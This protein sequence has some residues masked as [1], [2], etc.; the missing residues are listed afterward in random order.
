MARKLFKNASK[1]SSFAV[2]IS[3]LVSGSDCS[4]LYRQLGQYRE[5]LSMKQSTSCSHFG[6]YA[7]GLLMIYRIFQFVADKGKI[8]VYGPDGF[9]EKIGEKIDLVDGMAG[10]AGAETSNNE[11]PTP[12]IECERQW[13]E[14]LP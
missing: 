10:H 5:P 6:Q 2:R 13:L 1:K 11:H 9:I 7:F 3:G 8:K 14:R 4:N 12:N